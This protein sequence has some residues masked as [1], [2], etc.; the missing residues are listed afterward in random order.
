MATAYKTLTSNYSK[1]RNQ[2]ISD[3]KW[4]EIIRNNYIDNPSKEK[5]E[6]LKLN[7]GNMVRAIGS[8]WKTDIQEF[9]P[10]NHIPPSVFCHF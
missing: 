10:I 8:R 7:R 1:Y 2:W 5:E 4:M 6:K 3:D 9:T